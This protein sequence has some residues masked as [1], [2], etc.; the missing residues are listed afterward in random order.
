MP[1]RLT[2]RRVL[3]SPARRLD[4]NDYYSVEWSEADFN[5]AYKSTM[6][7]VCQAAGAAYAPCWIVVATAHEN[8]E[9]WNTGALASKTIQLN[10]QF[11][12]SGVVRQC[13]YNSANGGYVFL[14]SSGTIKARTSTTTQKVNVKMQSYAVRR[15]RSNPR[16]TLCSAA[17]AAKSVPSVQVQCFY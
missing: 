17:H 14:R 2:E 10:S 11:E 6:P 3:L 4:N 5:I 16:G 15:V 9:K 7:N 13:A 1:R 12:I 8:N